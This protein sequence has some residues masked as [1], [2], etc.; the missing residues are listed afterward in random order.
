MNAKEAEH[1]LGEVHKGSFGMHANGH[2]TTRKILRAGYYWL[3]MESD[4]A[5]M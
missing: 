5:S 4:C 3:T 2:A 1:M